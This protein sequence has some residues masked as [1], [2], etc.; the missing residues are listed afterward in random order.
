MTQSETEMLPL[1]PKPA[2]NYFDLVIIGGGPA[3]L[4][5][6]LYGARGNVSTLLIEKGLPGGE[7]NNTEEV[8]NYPGLDHLK[9][10]Q[11]GEMMTEHARR[12]G[13][14][15]QELTTIRSIDLKSQPKIIETDQGQF[16]ARSVIIATGSE[17]RKLNVPGEK[18]LAGKG[19][20]YCAVCD[21]AFFKNKHVVV[22]GGGNAAVEEGNFLTRYASK[23][24]LVHRRDTLRAEKII[25]TRATN[26]PKMNFIWWTTVEEII[27][28]ALG[29]TKVKL[30]NVQTGE[31][32]ELACDGVFI[33]VGLEP[34]IELFKEQIELDEGNRVITSEKLETN[35]PG[36]FAAGDV[37]VTPL[38]QAVTA[39]ADGSLAATTAIS[40]IEGLEVH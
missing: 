27:G 36:V 28:D 12:F 22:V 4:S 40:F 30:K 33:Y 37:R 5:A 23:V 19:V 7:L 26:N 9:G 10:P 31:V 16:K 14:Y 6:A 39:A 25:Q 34:N 18:E 11:I 32:S 8:E 17:H 29:V 2:D 21:G 38:R 13:A 24:T 35:I 20:S 15:F 3:G 1:I